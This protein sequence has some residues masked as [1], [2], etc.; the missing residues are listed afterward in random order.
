MTLD[1]SLCTS[2]T[3]A[4]SFVGF[5]SERLAEHSLCIGLK[6]SQAHYATNRDHWL[7]YGHTCYNF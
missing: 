6:W 7:F 1:L 4:L 5:A 2:R 3:K